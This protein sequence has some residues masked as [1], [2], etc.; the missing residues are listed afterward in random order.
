MPDSDSGGAG[1]QVGEKML[2]ID[3]TKTDLELDRLITACCSVAGNVKSVKI[4]RRPTPF[5]LVEMST[6][7]ETCSLAKQY[8][9]PSF[10]QCVLVHLKQENQAS[11]N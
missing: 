2:Q 8:G 10:G 7:D 3:L 5:A 1:E 9:R 4:H 6:H 11:R